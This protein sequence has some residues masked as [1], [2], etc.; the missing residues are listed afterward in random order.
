MRADLLDR[1]SHADSRIHRLPAALKLIV[2]LAIV[3]VTVVLPVGRWD[4]FVVVALLLITIA[5]ASRVPA[6]FILRRLVTL[7]P[8][9][10]GVAGMAMFQPHGGR[11]FL[12][13]LAKTTLCLLAMILLSSTTPFS[14]LLEV[15]KRAWVPDILVSTLALMYRYLFV[16]VD[17]A[18]RMRRARAS[19]T[20]RP[21]RWWTWRALGTVIGQLFV[22][23]TERAER[24]YA[25]MIARGWS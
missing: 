9:A 20:F 13:M 7:E 21:G 25:A 18:Q 17:E 14:A 16:L 19:R 4:G 11:I 3:I 12:T 24:I 15:M 8:L 1:W 6:R 2:A 22:R 10:L 23:S 5:A